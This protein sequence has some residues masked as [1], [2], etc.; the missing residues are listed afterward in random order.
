MAWKPGGRG[1]PP[2]T[3]TVGSTDDIPIEVGDKG[4]EINYNF[5]LIQQIAYITRANMVQ[6]D[7]AYIRGVNHLADLLNPYIGQAAPFVEQ[8]KTLD[9]TI[10]KALRARNLEEIQILKLKRGYAQ[11]K[12]SLLVGVMAFKNFLPDEG[13]IEV[14]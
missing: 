6:D 5:L 12:F 10:K 13:I 7:A 2:K 11:K 1:R 8:F 3:R 14:Y 4:H 9:E